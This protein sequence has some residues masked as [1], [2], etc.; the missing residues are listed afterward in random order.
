MRQHVITEFDKNNDRMLSFDEF[1]LGIN[2]TA[3]KNDQGWQ[4]SR[5]SKRV[6]EN[7]MFVRLFSSRLKIVPFTVIKTFR[8]F[9]M[10]SHIYQP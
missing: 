7:E 10:N 8:S 4:V 6:D 9:Q 2:G 5:F 1:Q 3:A